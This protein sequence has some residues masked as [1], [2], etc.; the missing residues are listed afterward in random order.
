MT[1]LLS[2][3]GFICVLMLFTSGV[4]PLVLILLFIFKREVADK[5][6]L[7]LVIWAVSLFIIGL[8]GIFLTIGLFFT[9]NSDANDYI[10]QQVSDF[11]E[12]KLDHEKAEDSD[13][14]GTESET[15][16]EEDEDEISETGLL[17]IDDFRY[18]SDTDSYYGVATVKGYATI[19][20][21]P[22]AFCE[23]NC[24][25][26][27]YVEFNITSNANTA[28]LDF[29]NSGG[30]SFA[31]ERIVTIGCLENDRIT[32]MN[33]SDDFGMVEYVNNIE[34]TQKIIKSSPENPITIQL[35]RYKYTSGKGAPECYS[36]FA[37][38]E[39]K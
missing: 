7:K 4:I 23:E 30:N 34:D 33:D 29:I 25:T 12:K 2:I 18:F 32:R 6:W 21:R 13:E 17:K 11:S 14:S 8:L 35:E 3:I 28:F 5:H 36:H 9:Q 39:V 38:V 24:P 20:T 27:D 31:S 15:E 16:S 19:S 22:Q 26:Y 1:Y 10:K 37:N